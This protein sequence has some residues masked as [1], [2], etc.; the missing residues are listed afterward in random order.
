[1]VLIWAIVAALGALACASLVGRVIT[2]GGEAADDEELMA[3]WGD[4]ALY[5]GLVTAGVASLAMVVEFWRWL[6]TL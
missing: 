4:T 3:A 2:A 6:I 5:L 1:M